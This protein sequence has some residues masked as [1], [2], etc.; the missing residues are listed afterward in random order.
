MLPRVVHCTGCQTHIP[1]KIAWNTNL[2]Q[3]ARI[4]HEQWRMIIAASGSYG[5]VPIAPI[6]CGVRTQG[7]LQEH[8][9]AAAIYR[10]SEEANSMSI[11]AKIYL[12]RKSHGP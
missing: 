3:I 6:L 2:I 1:E 8:P 4:I 10:Q 7:K 5:C 9:A 11:K 12:D